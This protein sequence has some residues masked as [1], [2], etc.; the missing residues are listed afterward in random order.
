[1]SHDHFADSSLEVISITCLFKLTANEEL[2]FD[3]IPGS[4]QDETKNC[5]GP[6]T[7][8]APNLGSTR[9]LISQKKNV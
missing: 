2:V 7:I 4:Y 6:H 8:N 1:M 5:K 9:D 3:W